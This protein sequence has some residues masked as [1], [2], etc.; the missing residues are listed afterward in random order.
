MPMN[1][2]VREMLPEKRRIWILRYSRSNDSR[3][4]RSGLPMIAMVVL[5]AAHRAL[6]VEDFG[7]QQV[8]FDARHAVAG[9]EDQGAFDDVAQLADIAGPVM[10]LQRGHR[11]LRDAPAAASAARRRSGRGNG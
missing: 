6:I 11:F 9:R 4:S 2:A 10:R 1:D 5:R 8:D 7:R 3:A